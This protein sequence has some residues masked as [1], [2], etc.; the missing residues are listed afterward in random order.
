MG[1]YDNPLEDE[2]N[3]KVLSAKVKALGGEA[4][5]EEIRKRLFY[6]DEKLLDRAIH[7]SPS[8]KQGGMKGLVAR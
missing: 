5:R 4:T 3:D 7:R 8:I 1:F 6:S 2:H